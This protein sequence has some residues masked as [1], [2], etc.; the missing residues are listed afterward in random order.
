LNIQQYISS[1][2]VESYVLGLAAKEESE[3]FEKICAEYPE[4][5]EYRE[6]FERSLE[7]TAMDHAVLPPATVK[8][9]I[10]A[11]IESED[12][13]GS[14]PTLIRQ[15]PLTAKLRTGSWV[16]W[17]AAASLLLLI[18]STALNFYFF[19][20]YKE[21]ISKYDELVTNQNQ[22]AAVNLD[23][24]TKLQGYETAFDKMRDPSMSLVKMTGTG[25]HFA[26]L[27]T[28]YWD[29]HTKDVYLLVNHLPQPAADKQ[30][31]LWALVDGKPVD[32]GI[33][34]MQE[35]FTFV[36]MKNIPVAQAFAITLEKKGGS[37]APTMDAMVVL[38]KVTG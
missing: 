5:K 31:Q 27:T 35:G 14:R 38:G 4:V 16:R 24:Q 8:S 13:E 3:E 17:L 20:Q 32:A 30:Y 26:S 18:G 34:D 28:V 10:F 1:G 36:R 9:R 29:T 12:Q 2:I 25:S 6:A 23:L 19:S 37:A 33:F 21:Y 11:E 15:V 7:K 22:M